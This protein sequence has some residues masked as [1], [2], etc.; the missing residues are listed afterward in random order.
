MVI[1]YFARLI[2]QMLVSCLAIF[3]FVA[4]MVLSAS[5][6]KLATTVPTASTSSPTGVVATPEDPGPED[7]VNAAIA[8]M[9]SERYDSPWLSGDRNPVLRL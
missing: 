4:A 9:M 6:T 1:S 8:S 5:F 3:V 7:P 2:E